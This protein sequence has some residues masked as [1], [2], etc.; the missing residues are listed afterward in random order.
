MNKTIIIYLVIFTIFQ[1]C[2]IS[3]QQY[4]DLW[5]INGEKWESSS[6]LPDFSFAGYHFGEDKL[7]HLEIVANV[8]K[9]GA[10][11]DGKTDCTEAFKKAIQMNNN[12]AIFIPAGQYLISDIIWIRKPDI[13]LRGEGPDKTVIIMTKELEDVKPNM[14]HNLGGRPCS[15]YSWSGGF[16]WV[17]GNIEK[18]KITSITADTKRGLNEL[19]VLSSVKLLKGQRITIQLTD[20]KQKSLLNHLYANDTGN[21]EKISHPVKIQ[22]INSIA[23]IRGD[24]VILKR[25]LRYDIQ[26]SWSP[27]IKTFSPDVKEVGI[28]DLSI[29]FPVKPY[30]GH[31]TERG[32]NGIAMNDVSDCWVKNIRISNCDSGIILKEGIFCTVDGLVI[33]SERRFTK[34]TTGHHGVTLGI[35]CLVNDFDFKTHFIH[36][37]TVGKLVS[38]NVI[39]NGKGI[40]LSLDHHKTAPN[41]NL[42]CNLDAGDGSEIWRC[43]GGPKIGKHCGTGETFWRIKAR[44]KIQWPPEKFGP[45]RINLIGITTDAESIKNLNGKWL[46]AIPPEKLLPIDLHEAQ[47]KKR[48]QK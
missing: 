40:N 28:E 10:K 18:E 9:F 17:K 33:D 41:E 31:F 44:K 30:K 32:M 47:L 35:D 48:L 8:K 25:P 43:G 34:R 42:F 6:R 23:E 38:G 46:E 5:G 21:T 36:D 26:K 7:P 1:T 29:K 39:K 4:S 3:A 16:I 24:K 14:G 19:A 20:D 27:I 11:G 37:F 22:M 45:D 2:N 13:V 12:G 15:M